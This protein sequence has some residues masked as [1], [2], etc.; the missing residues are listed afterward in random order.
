[1][2]P[3]MTGG[4]DNPVEV[5]FTPG[6]ERI[7]TTTFLQHPA[8][9]QRDGLIHAIYGGVYGKVHSVIDEH[10]RTGD[11]MPVLT[12]L[13]A[14]APC[15]LCLIES[16]GLGASHRGNLFACL[17]NMHK[18]TR[19]DLRPDGAT[20]QCATQDFLVC[21]D[22]D[23]HPTDVLEDADGS[24]IVIDTG[25]WYK[26]CCP[27]SAL[28]KPDIL[29]A[30]YRIRASNVIPTDDPRGVAIDWQRLSS[31]EAVTYLADE[32]P[33][34]QRQASR[35]LE[36]LGTQSLAALRQTL[37]EASSARAR[38]AAVWTAVRIKDAEAR[39]VVREAL[40]DPDAEV[41][42]AAAHG[43]SVHRDQQARGALERMLAAKEVG[44]A[45]QRV[46]A[47]ALG[48]LGNPQ[49]VAALCEAAATAEGRELQHSIAF[50]MIEIGAAEPLRAYL[51]DPRA[52]VRR[53]VVIALDQ[54][55]PP[56]LAP[57]QLVPFLTAEEPE[58]RQ[59]AT[60]I[61]GRHAEWADLVADLLRQR[62]RAGDTDPLQLDQLLELVPQLAGQSPI[63]TM[64]AELVIDTKV[65]AQRRRQ[66]LSAMGKTRLRQLPECWADALS[67]VLNAKDPGLTED[68]I[69][70]MVQLPKPKQPNA[71]L[72]QSLLTILDR[73]DITPSLRLKAVA[74]IPDGLNEVS[75]DLFQFLRT[76]LSS[77]N[78]V[79]DRRLAVDTLASARLT[80]EQLRQLFED[81]RMVGPM[82]LGS[83]LRVY[84]QTESPEIGHG[85]VDALLN[86]P[87]ASSLPGAILTQQTAHFGSDV[88]RR[89]DELLKR[90]QIDPT[91][92]RARLETLMS[93]LSEGDVRRG[94]RVFHSSKA[95]CSACHAMG[96]LGGTIGPDLTRIGGIRKRSELLE[97]IVFPSSSFVRSYEPL[98]VI[99]DDGLVWN[100][101]VKDQSPSELVL[102]NSERREI[103]ID[104]ESIEETRPG[105]VSIMPSG[106]DEQLTA[107]ELADLLAFLQDAK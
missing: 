41:R 76:R 19:H 59:T 31:I 83:L 46:A 94:H 3:V 62:L 1:V 80:D 55:S 105:K 33:W 79:S 61:A 11:V 27:T 81:V 67:I 43:V 64:I 32:R 16:N 45:N 4:M 29:G 96:Y 99:T 42:Q 103:R 24:L 89:S 107:Q 70:V 22:L 100:G 53:S 65:S 87:S 69:A 77:D 21:D 68:V 8:G 26:L 17:F 13:G 106:L 2:E 86:S 90:L 34:V 88:A 40:N 28:Q 66:L 95:A 78:E 82:E 49:S 84:E 39:A 52:K 7:F 97:A 38:I 10:P 36:S 9:G 104:R 18:V 71:R 37:R 30:I 25:G 60:W 98:T 51:A 14:A 58:I 91:Q 50:A 57:R 20:F 92:Q 85:L 5:V 12:H 74:A 63:Q 54:M 73:E 102:I 56:S 72:N 47:E 6:G 44:Q 101:T 75:D 23:F 93:E 48:R 15:G 35:R